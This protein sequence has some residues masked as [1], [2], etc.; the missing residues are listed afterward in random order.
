M[1]NSPPH[2]AFRGFGAPQTLF[3]LERH[4]DVI[5][6]RLGLDPIDVRRRNLIRD[7]QS[8]STGQ[9]IDD[10][11]DRVAVLDAALAAAAWPERRAAHAVFNASHA[12]RRR[13]IGLAAFYHGAGFTGDG[14]VRLA[15]RVEV[16][17]RPDG[18]VEVLASSTEMGQGATTVFTHIAAEHLGIDPDDV[19]IAEPDT[20][21]VPDSGPTVA[22]RTAMVVGRLLERACDALRG[23]LGLD[24]AARGAAVTDA[25]RAWHD[26]HRGERLIAEARYEPPAGLQWDPELYR[27]DAYGA[28]AWATY[29]AEVESTCAR[30]AR[31]CSTSS[32][33]RRSGRCSTRSS[34]PARS[35]VASSRASAGRSW[36]SASGATVR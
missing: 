13:G 12:D 22:S 35:R 10:G 7:G 17:G 27:G 33:C 20:S 1:T 25:I 18:T 19:I 8:T 29:I 16:V 21:R 36:R 11:T 15:S 9:V 34:R 26:T 2:G 28:F 32:P 31:P 4:M 14:E 5:A 30:T 24:P 3:A 23:R 6:R